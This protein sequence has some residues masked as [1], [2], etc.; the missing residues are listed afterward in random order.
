MT[1]RLRVSFAVLILLIS[2]FAK[3]S[4][5]GHVS[6]TA[7]FDLNGSTVK[8]DGVPSWPV[9]ANDLIE[10]HATPVTIILANGTR[11][12]LEPN[13]K[14]RIEGKDKKLVAVLLSGSG[15]YI[16]LGSAVALS[17]A[18]ALVLTETG[19]GPASHSTSTTT[20]GLPNP[21]PTTAH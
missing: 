15:K 5:V 21:S 10:T 20:T 1:S 17:T 13:S 19:G 2:G 7:P 14:L 4:P 6:A 18:V 9:Y 12:E 8:V 16:V 11:I 3:P